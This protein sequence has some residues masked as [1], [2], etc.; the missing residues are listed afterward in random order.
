MM[1]ARCLGFVVALLAAAGP[2]RTALAAPVGP[3]LERPAVMS[4]QASRSV[5]QS[6]ARAGDRL[7]AVGERGIVLLSDDAGKTWR[8]VAVPVSV[9]LTAVRFADPQHGW[10]VGH[11]GVVLATSDAGQTWTQQLDGR[12]A[13]Q[14]L[15]KDAQAAADVRAQANAERMVSEGADKPFLDAHFFDARHGLVIGAYNLAF[16]THDG[17][18]TWQPLSRRLDNPKAFHLYAVRARGNELL[19]AGEQGLVLRSSDQGRSFQRLQVP[20]KGS[21]FTAELPGTS[22]MLLAGLRGNVWKS[23]D[24][25]A[26]WVQLAMPVPMSITTS[27]QDGQGRVLLGNQAGMVYVYS[28]DALVP[29]ASKLPPLTGL[30]PLG[31]AQVLA[32]SVAGALSVNLGSP[33]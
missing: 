12:Q 27:A 4:A 32:L 21:F 28:G 9:G 2:S 20:Y 3:A 14:L 33:K 1:F 5:L 13:A 31:G 26:N 8:Q 17:G 6:A 23:S 29:A 15:L 10:I 19:I 11:G 18:T 25:G 24:D 22:E 30:L 7:V 16:E